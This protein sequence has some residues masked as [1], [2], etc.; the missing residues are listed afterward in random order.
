[1]SL[2]LRFA[3]LLVFALLNAPSVLAQS[4][5]NEPA[6]TLSVTDRR[7]NWGP[8]PEFMP[9]GCKLAVLHGDPSKPNADVLLKVPPSMAVANH[10]HSSA[11]RMVL[12]SGEL[13]VVYDGQ[14]PATLTPGMY[15]YGPAK[16]PLMP[17]RLPVASRRRLRPSKSFQ[18]TSSSSLRSSAAAAELQFCL[19]RNSVAQ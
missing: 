15:A 3:C 6:L 18:P 13:E 4:A 5:S 19:R 12:I 1:M 17:F 14:Q 11:E 7:V 8:C 16:L 10:W 9:V 2:I